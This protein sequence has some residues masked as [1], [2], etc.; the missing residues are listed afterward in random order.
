MKTHLD[1]KAIGIRDHGEIANFQRE[2][3]DTF[4]KMNA[5]NLNARQIAARIRGVVCFEADMNVHPPWCDTGPP[6]DVN[7]YCDGSVSNPAQKQFALGGSGIWHEGRTEEDGPLRDFEKRFL[8]CTF[9]NDGCEALHRY[10]GHDVDSYRTGLLG[11][12][13]ALGKPG[14]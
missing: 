13:G 2:L 4:I 8:D 7:A 10:A 12:P 3:D 9:A 6:R 11:I 1:R 14:G 5:V